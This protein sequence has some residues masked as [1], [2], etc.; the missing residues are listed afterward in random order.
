MDFDPR[1]YTSSLRNEAGKK[2]DTMGLE[3]MGY[4]VGHYGMKARIGQH[5]FEP[6]GRRWISVEHG[7]KIFF[8]GFQN[9]GHMIL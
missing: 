1:Q 7:T 2:R 9:H 4:A 6:A 8:N 3:P 5:D